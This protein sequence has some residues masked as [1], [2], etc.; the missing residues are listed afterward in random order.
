MDH[1]LQSA[2]CRS[3]DWEEFQGLDRKRRMKV[4]RGQRLHLA[5]FPTFAGCTSAQF[6]LNWIITSDF[7]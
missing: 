2:S 4:P 1:S 5:L 3:C 7:C 6:P